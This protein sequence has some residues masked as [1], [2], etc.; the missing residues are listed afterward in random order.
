[1]PLELSEHP[2]TPDDPGTCS[3]VLDHRTPLV[4][5]TDA[6]VSTDTIV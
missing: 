4:V 5:P 2:V 6:K 3:F 1:M